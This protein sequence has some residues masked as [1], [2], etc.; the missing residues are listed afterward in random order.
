MTKV[1]DVNQK[2][3]K[4][5]AKTELIAKIWWKTDFFCYIPNKTKDIPREDV[6]CGY[7]EDIRESINNVNTSCSIIF[8]AAEI[9]HTVSNDVG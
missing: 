6:D 8:D 7:L 2:T 1:A 4:K 3:T 5:P 9:S